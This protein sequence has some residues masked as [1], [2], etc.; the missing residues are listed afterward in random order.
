MTTREICLLNDSF[1]P[2]I[3]GVANAVTNYARVLTGSESFSAS[4]VTP[5]YPGADD[6]GFPYPVIRYPGLDLRKSVGYT[7]GNPFSERLLRELTRRD[8]SLLHTHCPVMSGILSRELRARMNIPVVMTYHTKFDIDIANITEIEPARE[9][10]IRA[11]VAS[12]SSCDELWTVSDGAGKNIQSLGYEGDYIVM[13]NGVDIPRQQV[14]EE[15]IRALT[16]DPRIP[17]DVPVFLFVGRMMWY[18]GIRIILDALA[19]LK[20]R[21]LPFRMVFIG[22]GADQDEIKTY[23]MQLRLENECLFLGKIMDRKVL[24]AW[25]GRAD[26]FLFPSTFDTNGLVVREAAACS[27]AT[28]MIGGSCAAEGVTDGRNGLLI[29]ENAASLAVCLATMLERR[30]YLKQL[31]ERASAELYLSWD[32]AVAIA[33]ER[34]EIVLDRWQSGG[35][36]KHRN[37]IDGAFRA[38]GEILATLERLNLRR[39]ELE[40]RLFSDLLWEDGTYL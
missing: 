18:K 25:Y 15:T 22:G 12:V 21:H 3:D 35:Y 16:A 9:A 20:S 1:P 17:D 11:L 24:T 23:C 28:V 34:Y 26:L 8:L 27:L 36:P 10:L 37:P 6:S 14:P 39:R 7:A 40:A 31:G 29:E 13:P 30:D 5:E 2:L 33:M 38:G 32:D 19:A 4:V